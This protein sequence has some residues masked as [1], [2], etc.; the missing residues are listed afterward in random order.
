MGGGGRTPAMSVDTA[1]LLSKVEDAIAGLLDAIIDHQIEEY[2][3]G[4]RKIRRVDFDKTLDVL[5][6][7]RDKLKAIVARTSTSPVRVAKL[8]RARGLDR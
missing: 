2:Q 8:G 7:R 3:V 4:N 5:F 1:T 6:A